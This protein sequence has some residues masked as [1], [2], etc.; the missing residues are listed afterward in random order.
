MQIR[1]TGHMQSPATAQQ[2]AGSRDVRISKTQSLWGGARAA[3]YTTASTPRSPSQSLCPP[4]RVDG[5]RPS[6]TLPDVVTLTPAPGCKGAT[7]DGEAS[8][9]V[10]AWWRRAASAHGTGPGGQT[11]DLDSDA[12]GNLLQFWPQPLARADLQIMRGPARRC[13]I[14]HR[15]RVCHGQAPGAIPIPVN[16][17]HV[18]LV[19]V[20]HLNPFLSFGTLPFRRDPNAS[21][22][23]PSPFKSL[24]PKTWP[25]PQ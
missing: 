2:R 23:L 19:G 22:R 1:R 13:P 12:R 16:D 11:I 24:P 10:G 8:G 3:S 15:R 17:L 9:L 7:D 6:G 21:F 18:P 14:A 25:P 4:D 5:N 20:V